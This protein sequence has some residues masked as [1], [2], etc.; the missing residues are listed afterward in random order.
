M[1]FLRFFK[2]NFFHDDMSCRL[3]NG[4]TYV[5]NSLMASKGDWQ[6]KKKVKIATACAVKWTKMYIKFFFRKT[7]WWEIKDNLQENFIHNINIYSYI[8]QNVL[9]KYSILSTKGTF[10]TNFGQFVLIEYLIKLLLQ[11]NP[12]FSTFFS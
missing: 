12:Q 6:S 11:I 8:K 3:E 5:K 2:R 10:F 1:P 4:T 9:K 7:N